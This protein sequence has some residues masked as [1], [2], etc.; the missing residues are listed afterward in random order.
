MKNLLAILAVAI[1]G[2]AFA[3]AATDGINSFT[4]TVDCPTTSLL[5]NFVV[6]PLPATMTAGLASGIATGVCN[7]TF[8]FAGDG[9]FTYTITASGTM[10][11]L[12]VTYPTNLTPAAGMTGAISTAVCNAEVTHI[13]SPLVTVPAGAGAGVVTLVYTLSALSN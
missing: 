11:S 2:S 10:P 12:W 8:K 4:T 13:V 5:S 9:T 6:T 1:L 3:L 7:W